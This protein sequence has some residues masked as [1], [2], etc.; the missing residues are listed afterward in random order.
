MERVLFF[1]N[2]L[3]I[4]RD[5]LHPFYFILLY[6]VVWEIIKFFRRLKGEL[7]EFAFGLKRWGLKG[8]ALS[9]TSSLLAELKGFASAA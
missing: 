4:E 8:F 5:L 2:A 3:G 1:Q 9:L 6:F 7:K